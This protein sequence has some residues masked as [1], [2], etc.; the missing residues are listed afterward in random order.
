MN[1][2]G[3][4]QGDD[5]EIELG[6]ANVQRNVQKNLRGARNDGQK[7]FTVSY[8]EDF[9]SK[10]GRQKRSNTLLR[11]PRFGEKELAELTMTCQSLG[12]EFE[13]VEV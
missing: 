5:V 11:S 12:E 8:T 4:H 6:S 2:C 13:S 7:N 1:R 10:G 9:T 3:T